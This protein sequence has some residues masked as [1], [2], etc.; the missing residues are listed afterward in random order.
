MKI[1]LL[2]YNEGLRSLLHIL[3]TD[4]HHEVCLAFAD[5]DDLL[6][7]FTDRHPAEQWEGIL[8]HPDI[9]VVIL[10]HPESYN[11]V[12]DEQLRKLAQAGMPMVVQH[13][14]CESIVG[15]EVEMIRVEHGSQ[16]RP[17]LP[18]LHHPHLA[19]IANWIN[20]P[21]L[22]PIGTLQLL[23]MERHP[24][25]YRP[26]DLMRCFSGDLAI[27]ECLI[28][29]PCRLNAAGSAHDD[30]EWRQ[31]NLNVVSDNGLMANW[32]LH[33][34]DGKSGAQILLGGSTGQATLSL[35]EN[36]ELSLELSTDDG[37][38]EVPIP[39]TALPADILGP[40]L[41]FRGE[42]DRWYRA[43]RNT[44]FAEMIP[45]CLRRGRAVDIPAEPPSENRSFKGA[46]SIASCGILMALLGIL[47]A[48]SVFEGFQ[49]PARH[50]EYQLEKQQTGIDQQVQE[51]ERPL[52]LRIWPV[53]PILL[54]LLLQFL[55]VL[56]RKK[57]PSAPIS[58]PDGTD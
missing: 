49:F 44:E 13:P 48:Y 52:F 26:A 40:L 39:S 50:N 57:R 24:D 3:A 30:P 36:H 43:V 38:S 37:N 55:L 21:Q 1:G 12:T 4:P 17:Y 19:T 5:G 18:A 33:R 23:S 42:D 35:D 31:L 54:F 47:F 51:P 53:Y 6:D 46:M 29:S 28:G 11:P 2:G 7:R 45:Y 20:D 14:A 22:S 56:A 15:Y 58:L 34:R 27:L 32:N 10:A 25:S 9:D 8:D 41:E 16:I